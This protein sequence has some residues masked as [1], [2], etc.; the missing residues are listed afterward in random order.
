M[1][2]E[3][4]S[5]KKDSHRHHY[6]PQFILR[7][8]SIRKDGFVKFYDAKKKTITNKPTEEIFLYNDLYRD[9]N[10]SN[11]PT[12]IESDLAKYENEIAQLFAK[13]IYKGDEIEL[14]IEE[15]DKLKLFLTIMGLRNKKAKTVFGEDTDPRILEMYKPYLVNNTLEDLWKKNLGVLVNCRSLQEVIDSKEIIDPFRHYVFLNTFGFLG[16]YLIFAERRGNEDFIIG[17]SYPSFQMAKTKEG[18]DLPMLNYYPISP[19]RVIILAVSDIRNFQQSARQISETLLRKPTLI[20]NGTALKYHVKKIYE[21]DVRFINSFVW[22]YVKDGVACI[23]D[24]RITI[25]E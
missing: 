22:M 24:E 14:T 16:T 23:D 6:I 15:E 9:E 20:K 1:V 18:I 21:D 13:K 10:N 3:L 19:N 5:M 17:D 12:K 8:F 7:N 2:I 11:D 25:P 4:Y